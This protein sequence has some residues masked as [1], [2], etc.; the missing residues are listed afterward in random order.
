MSISLHQV[1]LS[2]PTSETL[3]TALT[4][5]KPPSPMTRCTSKWVRSMASGLGSGKA[6][7]EQTPILGYE[8]EPE[9]GE[10]ETGADA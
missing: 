1:S 8:V 2:D 6:V 4:L 3:I 9:R 5:P 7:L 10:A